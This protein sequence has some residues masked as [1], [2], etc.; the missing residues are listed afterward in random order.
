MVALQAP[1]LGPFYV[2]LLLRLLGF[3][4][5]WQGL[6]LDNYREMYNVFFKMLLVCNNM[7]TWPVIAAGSWHDTWH[8][9]HDLM[10]YNYNSIKIT[11]LALFTT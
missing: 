9:S 5:R 4:W 8:L 7:T 1:G 6:E 10:I 3:I 2:D 11:T